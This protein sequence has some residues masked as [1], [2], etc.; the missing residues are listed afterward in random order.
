MND[1]SFFFLFYLSFH[2]TYTHTH[3]YQ[4]NQNKAKHDY[5]LVI[6][7]VQNLVTIDCIV[8]FVHFA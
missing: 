6:E 8:G 5:E 4:Y 2:A 3:T 1:K 7:T